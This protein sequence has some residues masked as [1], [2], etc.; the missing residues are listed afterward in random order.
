MEAVEVAPPQARPAGPPGRENPKVVD[1]RADPKLVK[2][3]KDSE[4]TSLNA[5][6][7]KNTGEDAAPMPMCG[8]A[9]SCLTWLLR[10]HCYANC[11][12]AAAHIVPSRALVKACHT[13]M[14]KCGC[15]KLD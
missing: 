13:L 3:F 4:F 8:D 10:G 15:P 6:L 1:P 11:G 12:R 7:A 9:E 14:D 5:M 2:R